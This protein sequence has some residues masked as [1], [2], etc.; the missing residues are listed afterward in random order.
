MQV[1]TERAKYL[2]VL[3]QIAPLA[4]EA[5]GDAMVTRVNALTDSVRTGE[6]LVPIIGGFSSGKSTLLNTLIGRQLL[7]TAILPET[8]LAAELRYGELEHIDAF[9]GQEL[10][11]SF[12]LNQF[13]EINQSS[14]KYT[15]LKIYLNCSLLRDLEPAILVDMPGFESQVDLHNKAINYYLD[16]GAL[17]IGLISCQEGTVTSSMMRQLEKIDGYGCPFHIFVSKTDLRPQNEVSAVVDEIKAQLESLFF[18]QDIIVGSVNSKSVEQ[19]NALLANI[20]CNDLFR[21]KFLASIKQVG[22]AVSSELKMQ[23]SVLEQTEQ[24]K[25][26]QA[27]RSMNSALSEL[28]KK[29]KSLSLNLDAQFNLSRLQKDVVDRV[30]SDLRAHEDQIISLAIAG[31]ME[32]A[33]ATFT[34]IVHASVVSALNGKLEEIDQKIFEQYQAVVGSIDQS[35]KQNCFSSVDF[36]GQ[37]SQL[38]RTDLNLS[39]LLVKDPNSNSCLAKDLSATVLMGLTFLSNLTGPLKLIISGIIT[40]LNNILPGILSKFFAKM[41]EESIRAQASEMLENA[42]IPQVLNSLRPQVLSL[43]TQEVRNKIEVV[44]KSFAQVVKEKQAAMNAIVEQ[45]KSESAEQQAKAAELKQA[46]AQIDNLLQT[47]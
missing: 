46:A 47:I 27:I 41:N 8:A 14:D 22:E 21:N 44:S 7:P 19:V 20:D 13:E 17:Y 29:Q 11:H 34:D 1:I 2:Q 30:E 9:N 36:C 28:D 3:E 26:D 15:H 5:Q 10:V 31:N 18:G 12:E 23:A 43:L 33:Q 39:Q 40:L 45:R 6:L 25:I 35:L 32:G 38:V 24:E 4:Q 16:K 42:F 37:V